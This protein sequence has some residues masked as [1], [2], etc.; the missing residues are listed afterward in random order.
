MLFLTSQLTC[1]GSTLVRLFACVII[2][3]VHRPIHRRTP[4][5][6]T[7]SRARKL[8]LPRC[9]VRVVRGRACLVTAGICVNCTCVH[10]TCALYMCKRT[11]IYTCA[12]H[13]YNCAQMCFNRHTLF[14]HFWCTCWARRF[15]KKVSLQESTHVHLL[16]KKF[17]AESF[18]RKI[19][20][21][22]VSLWSLVFFINSLLD[23][24]HPWGKILL[25][26]LI[27][28]M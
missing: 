12:M 9:A 1:I 22:R 26:L 10:Y 7:R 24:M 6:A 18:D 23:L 13:M 21:T 5:A 19:R 14:V 28:G 4:V 16:R 2:I 17:G 25:L 11:Y 8:N 15:V 3:H 20:T 27:P